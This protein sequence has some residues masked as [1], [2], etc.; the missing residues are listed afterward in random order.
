MSNLYRSA[1]S[2]KLHQEQLPKRRRT[3]ADT[4][5]GL[6]RGCACGSR[7]DTNKTNRKQC[8]PTQ[9]LTGPFVNPYADLSA[10]SKQCQE[11]DV[12]G[13]LNSSNTPGKECDENK[14]TTNNGKVIVIYSYANN[15]RVAAASK[16]ASSA[17]EGPQ[18]NE[19]SLA[20]KCH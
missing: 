6:V 5:V 18:P 4:C 16:L 20:S 9:S 8:R 11:Q 1:S 2:A 15:D 17:G 14:K 13:R 10:N 12:E 19:P 3:C 7:S